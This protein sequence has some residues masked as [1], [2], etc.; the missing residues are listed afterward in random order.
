MEG[1]RSV[2]DLSEHEKTENGIFRVLI[3]EDNLQLPNFNGQACASMGKSSSCMGHSAEM[4][5]L[6]GSKKKTHHFFSLRFSFR[7]LP[8]LHEC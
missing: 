3:P 1:E 5:N 6:W 4:V 2:Q 8:A 7:P